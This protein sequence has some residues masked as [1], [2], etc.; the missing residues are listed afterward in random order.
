MTEQPDEEK[1]K[2]RLF[3]ASRWDRPSIA[4]GTNASFEE[5]MKA[6]LDKAKDL[7]AGSQH[8]VGEPPLYYE[9]PSGPPPLELPAHRRA[10]VA[11]RTAEFLQWV[12][13]GLTRQEALNMVAMEIQVELK[14]EDDR[15]RRKE[16]G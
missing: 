4:H 8:V 1:P 15:R 11:T 14:Y 13:G 7:Q 10:H 5:A 6:A 3:D 16:E 9:E 2:P 12:S